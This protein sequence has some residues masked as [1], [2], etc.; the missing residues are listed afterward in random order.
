MLRS[1][2]VPAM[3]IPLRIAS[4]RLSLAASASKVGAVA[5]WIQPDRSWRAMVPINI[6]LSLLGVE[7]LHAFRTG[8]PGRRSD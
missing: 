3:R 5:F 1:T 4:A 6:K 2:I 8:H 7:D